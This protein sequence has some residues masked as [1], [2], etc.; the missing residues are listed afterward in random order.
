[1]NNLLNENDLRTIL[2][3]NIYWQEASRRSNAG[4][5]LRAEF[6]ELLREMGL[7]LLW[8]IADYAKAQKANQPQQVSHE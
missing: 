8:V 3:K 7:K 2:S 4:E 5:I 6:N 1:M